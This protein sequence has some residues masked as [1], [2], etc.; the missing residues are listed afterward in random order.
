MSDQRLCL[1]LRKGWT[2]VINCKEKVNKYDFDKKKLILKEI[3]R[4]LENL[5][6]RKNSLTWKALLGFQF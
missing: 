2:K 1:L 4:L 6:L 3:L 5:I